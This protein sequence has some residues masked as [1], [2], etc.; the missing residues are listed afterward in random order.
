MLP[1]AQKRGGRA[2]R[3]RLSRA[4]NSLALHKYHGAVDRKAKTRERDGARCR[5]VT[6][7]DSGRNNGLFEV[8]HSLECHIERDAE[9]QGEASGGAVLAGL[10]STDGVA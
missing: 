7:I 5:F 1:R 9:D 10:N 2:E 4:C 8:E 6:V 3:A